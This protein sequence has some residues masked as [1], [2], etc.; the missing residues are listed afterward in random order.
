MKG[1]ERILATLN[2]LLADE[3][4]AINQYMVHSELC[5]NWGYE[6]LHEAVEKRAF[7]EMRHAERLIERIIFLEG[8]PI[9]SRLNPIS[10][11][12]DVPAQ[13]RNDLQAE[14]GAVKSY[15]EGIALAVEVA[16]NGTR[17][18]LE[19]ILK[20]EEDHVDWIEA[21]MD[22]IEQMGIQSYL[23]QQMRS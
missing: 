19:S 23:S 2:A 18:L 9:V 1:N 4:T 3:L 7:T 5:S 21:Q 16:D 15:N 14:L 6:R 22:Q 8:Q 12:S 17:E 10:I 13:L 11:G 20:D